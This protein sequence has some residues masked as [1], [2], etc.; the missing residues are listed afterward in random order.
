MH[1]RMCWQTTS[2]V[3]ILLASLYLTRGAILKQIVSGLLSLEIYSKSLCK[4]ILASGTNQ[5]GD[6]IYYATK[7]FNTLYKIYVKCDRMTISLLG[8]FSMNVLVLPYV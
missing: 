5:N 7:L 1:V 6:N 3:N 4:M 2:H 8:K